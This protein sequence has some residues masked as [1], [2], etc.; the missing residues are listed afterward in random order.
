M[1][2]TNKNR[3]GG[4]TLI[5]V[6]VVLGLVFIL[7]YWVSA[8]LF[9]GQRVTSISEEALALERIL[10]VTQMSVMQGKTPAG[11]SLV[12]YSV[13]F[14]NDRYIVFPGV[15]YDSGNSLN[16]VYMLPETMRFSGIGFPGQILTFARISGQVR[17][18]SSGFDSVMLT[19]D[20]IAKSIS[21]SVNSAGVVF[22]TV[23]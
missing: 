6:V 13:R 23:L 5:E 16:T 12:D 1:T 22:I 3:S 21:V 19:D 18:Y 4:F 9:R 14:E 7:M 2:H 10:R 11:G 17:D 15:V 8:S 20:S